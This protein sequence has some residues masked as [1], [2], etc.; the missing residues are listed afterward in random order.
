MMLLACEDVS[1]I[2]NGWISPGAIHVWLYLSLFS[3]KD[4]QASGVLHFYIWVPKN[5]L[6]R[7]YRFTRSQYIKC[8]FISL[9]VWSVG[10][11]Y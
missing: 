9:G 6:I 10:S 4:A 11:P 5:K 3:W 1:M 2:F 8:L 7:M